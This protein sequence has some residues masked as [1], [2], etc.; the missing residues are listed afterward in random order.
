MSKWTYRVIPKQIPAES[1][2]AVVDKVVDYG[3]RVHC[4]VTKIQAKSIR[5]QL[6]D[7]GG[8]VFPDGTCVCLDE[9]D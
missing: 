5:A 8:C 6:E 1:F 3:K 2:R 7:H 4:V 9:F